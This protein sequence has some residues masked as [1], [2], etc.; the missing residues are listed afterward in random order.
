MLGTG[1]VNKVFSPAIFISKK[2]VTNMKLALTNMPL[3]H[4]SACYSKVVKI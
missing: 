3:R 4:N 2:M 1:G